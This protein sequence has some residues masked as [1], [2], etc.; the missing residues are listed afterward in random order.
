M[1]KSIKIKWIIIKLL[2]I[3]WI[4]L[5]LGSCNSQNNIKDHLKLE[6]KLAG[7]WI[8]KAFD[9]ELHEEWKLN[10]KGWMQQQGYYIENSDTSYA[11]VTQIQKV[12][13]DIILFSIIR[14]SNPKIFKSVSSNNDKMIFEN[15]DYKNPFE[16][17]YEFISEQN[18]RRTIRGY[19][20]DSLVVYEFN[21]EKQ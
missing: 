14:N 12:N 19:E 7:K 5:F 4:G 13:N 2:M 9:G 3:L 16:V 11:A 8:A 17:T 10:D 1:S 21:F 6:S 18:Y 15:K 20:N